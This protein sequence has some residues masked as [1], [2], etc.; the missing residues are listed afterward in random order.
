M[1]VF[2][3]A[4]NC[5]QH[6]VLGEEFYLTHEAQQHSFENELRKNPGISPAGPKEDGIQVIKRQDSSTTRQ[7]RP[8]PLPE[9]LERHRVVLPPD[10]APRGREAVV[11]VPLG[12]TAGL[13]AGRGEAAHLAVL[14]R[15]I[16]DPVDAR[17]LADYAVGWVNQDNLRPRPRQHHCHVDSS[18]IGSK[19]ARINRTERK[20]RWFNSVSAKVSPQ[21]EDIASLPRV[22]QAVCERSHIIRVMKR[23]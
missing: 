13:L 21:T 10:R 12:D 20:M 5:F 23:E 18:R 11:A 4:L 15:G 16:A 22:R 6:R 9:A 8:L 2:A 17:V 1:D 14:H 7:P 19:Y 3:L